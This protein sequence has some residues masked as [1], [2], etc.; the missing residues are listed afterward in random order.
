MSTQN[1]KI[2][3]VALLAF[4]AL[5]LAALGIGEMAGGEG[6][7]IQHIPEA[8][9]LVILAAAAWKYPGRV[10]AILVVVSAVLLAIWSALALTSDRHDSPATMVLVA[11]MLFLPPL[12]AGIL[13]LMANRTVFGSPQGHA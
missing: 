10:G 4:P 12:V 8:L 1:L 11:A 7:G 3:A 6:S 9:A 5:L 13:L 2:L